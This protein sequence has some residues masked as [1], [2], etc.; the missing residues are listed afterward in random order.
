MLGAL[1]VSTL[2]AS[3]ACSSGAL[4]LP[5]QRARSHVLISLH[6]DLGL[7]AAC[8]PVGPDL[9]VMLFLQCD[10]SALVLDGI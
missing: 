6:E 2:F 5:W 9:S 8:D 4:A 7:P 10:P 3:A 1:M